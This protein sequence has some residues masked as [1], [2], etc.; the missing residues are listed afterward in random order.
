MASGALQPPR[1]YARSMLSDVRLLER[2][3]P[4][5]SLDRVREQAAAGRGSVALITGEPGI[6]KTALA[7]AF[8]AAASEQ[9]RV[10]WGNCDDISIPRPLGP[11]RDMTGSGALQA[12]LA[13]EAPA[14]TFHALLL[15]ELAARPSPVVMV[16]EDVHW[17]DQATIDA[18]TVIGRRIGRVPAALVLT[19]RSGELGPGHPLPAALDSVRAG[20]SLFLELSPLSRAAV[21]SLAGDDAEAIYAASGGNPFYVTELAA[22]SAADLPPTVASAVRGRVARLGGD[23]RRLLELVSIAPS[24]LATKVLDAVAPG[25]TRAAEEPERHQLIRVGPEHVRFRHELAREAVRSSVPSARRRSLH[26]DLLG[27][28]LELRADPAEIVYHAEQAGET[29]VVADHVWEAARRAAAVESNREAHA[30]FR[31]ALDFVERLAPEDQAK[32]YEEAGLAAYTVDRLPEAFSAL[33]D[34]A[35]IYADV[36]D[37]HAVGRCTRLLSRCHW[38]AGEGEAA[39]E[40]GI[41]AIKTLEPLGE[42][43]ELARAYSGLSQLAMLAGNVAQTVEWG[44]KAA[45]LARRLGA[46]AV[47]VHALINLGSARIQV[48]PERTE[49]LLE[50]HR[51]ADALG[52]RHEAVRA[53]LNLGYSAI[54]WARPDIAWPYT[55]R[56][57][58]YAEEHQVDTL[59]QYTLAMTAWLLLRQG[60][61]SEAERIAGGAAKSGQSVARLLADTVFAELAVR[62]GD[63]D[64][65]GR[66]EVLA[67][68]VGKTKELQRVVPVLQLEV[69]RSLLSGEPLPRDRFS[70][71]SSLMGDS[72]GW[73]EA[74]LAAWAKVCGLDIGLT[75]DVPEPFASMVAGDWLRAGEAFEAIGWG[76]ESALMRSLTDDEDSLTRALEGARAL[77]S[78][79]LERRIVDRMKRV[80]VPVPGRPRGATQTNPAGLTDRQLEIAALLAHGS[81]NKE[82]AARLDLSVRTVE[83][84]VEAVLDKLGARRRSEAA[85]RFLDLT[86]PQAD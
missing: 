8:A 79:P 64:A 21:A 19:Y 32:L 68:Q 49:Q 70:A 52:D 48:D 50:A 73:S 2:E 80:G 67:G 9:A 75:G 31:R 38:F 63:D 16:I 11:F 23:A 45:D 26:R 29:Q 78:A 7:S 17:A 5:A 77:G 15:D 36:G 42:S 37:R 84:H 55:K 59:L 65:V 13:D 61:W 4:L 14:H 33:R 6:G 28:L 69:E 57:V 10:L 35:R 47:L 56:A 1:G 3:G 34:A 86:G 54:A 46:D 51:L 81:S 25:W 58:A 39:K 60:D 62:R 82:I 30:H 44:D 43:V 24:R 22:G 74:G 72:A 76:F 85:R 66:L 27:V 18:I 41:E 40:T 83:H 53:K 12:A 71:A 20:I